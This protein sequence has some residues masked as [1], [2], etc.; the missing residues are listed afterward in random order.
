MTRQMFVKWSLAYNFNQDENLT[1]GEAMQRREKYGRRDPR[2]GDL[3]CHKKCYI[4]KQGSQ[5]LTNKGVT[6]SESGE[7]KRKAHFKTWKRGHTNTGKF[8]GQES[9]ASSKRESMD[10]A[11]FYVEM[12]EYLNG[13]AKNIEPFFIKS[14]SG[15][16]ETQH[17]F[18]ITHSKEI[19]DSILKSRIYIIDENKRKAKIRTKSTVEKDF[20]IIVIKISEYTPEDLVDF[21]RGG[22]DKFLI[23]WNYLKELTKTNP[24]VPLL[25]IFPKDQNIIK[26]MISN[27]DECNTREFISN[28]A[29]PDKIYIRKEDTPPLFVFN[30]HF[31]Y[32]LLMD[33]VEQSR[34]RH[35]SIRH[36]NYSA[37]RKKLHSRGVA[38]WNYTNI[39]LEKLI[40]KDISKMLDFLRDNSSIKER[41]DLCIFLLANVNLK[42]KNIKRNEYYGI[43]KYFDDAISM[44]AD[45]VAISSSEHEVYD[46]ISD[47][48]EFDSVKLRKIWSLYNSG[49]KH[50]DLSHP[51]ITDKTFHRLFR[52]LKRVNNRVD[53]IVKQ[54][55]IENKNKW[56]ES[57]PGLVEL[58]DQKLLDELELYQ[59]RIKNLSGRNREAY[60]DLIG[61]KI[62]VV[63][64]K[65]NSPCYLRHNPEMMEIGYALK[66]EKEGNYEHL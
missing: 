60:A 33:R 57:N 28:L 2:A 24:I 53:S 8:C 9:L 64:S 22:I 19:G 13:L 37:L 12:E 6:D 20:F 41:H 49:R 5:L 46:L 66:I 34:T 38:S 35:S 65:L 32:F 18:E 61:L 47:D 25:K 63:K 56:L 55:Y 58:E 40:E 11:N 26:E 39:Y 59:T 43:R 31:L 52:A 23:E 54:K 48:E 36:K 4:S 29:Q 16:K 45:Y 3:W 27:F 30:T 21:Q 7:V 15:T 42:E 1:I 14:V 50:G 62:K 17:D 10:Y 44:F 51:L